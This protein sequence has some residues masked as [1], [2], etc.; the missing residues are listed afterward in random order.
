MSDP[1]IGSE[2][3]HQGQDLPGDHRVFLVTVD[4][5]GDHMWS[6]PRTITTLNAGFLPRF[7]ELCERFGVKPTYLATY[8]MVKDQSFCELI[9]AV[10]D[11]STGEIG[12]HLHAWNNPPYIP[13]SDD[14]LFH[15]PYLIEYPKEVMRQKIDYLTALL[16]DTFQAPVRSH[17]AGRWAFNEAYALM[18]TD[19]GYTVDCSVTPHVSWKSHAGLPSGMGGTDYSEFPEEP[20][21]VDLSDISRAGKSS[22]LE[23]PVTCF[24][25]RRTPL[26]SLVDGM[27]PGNA[28]RRLVNLLFS[29]YYMLSLRRLRL[30]HLHTIIRKCVRDGRNCAE[31]SLHSSELMPGCSPGFPQKRSIERLYGHLERLF[32]AATKHYQGAT[33][34]EYYDMRAAQR[35]EATDRETDS[36]A[37]R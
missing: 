21:F 24:E 35:A 34:T 27:K 29:S 25:R 22:L 31:L 3:P 15:Q 13:I 8:E 2:R 12:M 17:R 30:H 19:K 37:D 5:E 20:Y 16:E 1:D 28:F 26:N 9:R 14:D 36:P 7:Q 23:V 33:L 6:K 32:D 11:K 10:L 18:L 4:C